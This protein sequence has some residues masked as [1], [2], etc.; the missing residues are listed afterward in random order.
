MVWR[1]QS[2][3]HAFLRQTVSLSQDSGLEKR[4][5]QVCGCPLLI[6]E[7]PEHGNAKQERELPMY[8]GI[9][10]ECNFYQTSAYNA[11]SLAAIT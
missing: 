2:P 10:R 7:Q 9:Y 1:R 11:S 8:L 6:A 4:E 3:S 5:N